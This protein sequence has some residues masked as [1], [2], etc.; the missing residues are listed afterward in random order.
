MKRLR[1]RRTLK[2]GGATTYTRNLETGKAILREMSELLK[3]ELADK[4]YL[5]SS[6][7][8]QLTDQVEE[9]TNR[10]AEVMGP[11][12]VD[13]RSRDRA[14]DAAFNNVSELIDLLVNY[15]VGGRRHVRG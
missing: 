8:Q 1:T 5:T 12:P 11:V 4:T 7:K 15:R 2:R 9:Y 10:L 14:Y 6:H 3:S 13:V